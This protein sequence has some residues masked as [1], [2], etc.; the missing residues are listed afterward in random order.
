M[1]ETHDVPLPAQC[2]T[3][4]EAISETHVAA[5][6]QE[7]LPPVQPVIRRFDITRRGGMP[8]TTIDREPRRD[9]VPNGDVRAA[10]ALRFTA[11]AE[12]QT[13]LFWD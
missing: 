8:M 6:Y 5:Q 13:R 11:P 9:I 10:I 4:G 12:P 2:P 7:D 1:Q 3:C